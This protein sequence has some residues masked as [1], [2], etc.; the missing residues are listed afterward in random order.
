MSPDIVSVAIR[1]IG[2]VFVLQAAGAAIFVALFNKHID[3]TADFIHKL[4]LLASLLGVVFVMMHQTLIAARMTGE[5]NGV[6]DL[7]M[8]RLAWLSS[9][10]A[11]HAM[12][13][14]GL[15]L[16]AVETRHRTKFGLL[17]MIGVLCIA[18]AFTL[19]GH[20]SVHPLHYILAVLLV[21]HLFIVAF[22]FGALLPLWM[23]TKRE[24]MSAATVV[25]NRFSSIATYSV[26]LIAVAGIVMTVLIAGGIPSLAEPYGA[27]IF[28]KA[29]GFTMLM[30]LAALNKW[31]LVPTFANNLM[32]SQKALRRSIAAEF[33]LIIVVLS[34][35][36]VMTTFFSPNE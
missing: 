6:M 12:Q 17:S 9:D 20:T 25:L 13:V 18:S 21:I 5:F 1:A 19:I 32:Q 33:T 8:Q 35:T 26:P 10:G 36:A 28:A 30:G 31:R 3:A 29:A 4:T 27:L 23:V 24:P 22:W 14:F 11:S 34:V 2:F 15:L 16:V 7:S